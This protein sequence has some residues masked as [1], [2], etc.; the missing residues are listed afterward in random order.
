MRILKILNGKSVILLDLF[1]YL[2]DKCLNV[3]CKPNE[4]CESNSGECLCGF[5]ESCA[6]SPW[7]PTCIHIDETD[8]YVCECGNSQAPCNKETEICNEN[9]GLCVEGT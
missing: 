1:Y 5:G 3:T 6:N 2:D 4:R 8:T 9:H 7:A